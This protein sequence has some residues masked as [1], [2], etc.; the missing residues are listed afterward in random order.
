MPLHLAPTPAA[1]T[2]LETAPL[3]QLV[4]MVVDQH[5]LNDRINAGRGA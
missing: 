5:M 3:A 1:N 4:G 2:P